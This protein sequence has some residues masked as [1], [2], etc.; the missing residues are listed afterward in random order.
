MIATKEY[1]I[2]TDI[3]STTT[4]AILLE[5][6]PLRIVAQKS[7]ATTV[8]APYNDV[9]FGVKYAIRALE[10]QSGIQLLADK[11]D[12]PALGFVPGIQYLSSSSAGGGLQILVIGLT[13]FDSANSAKRAAYGAGGIIL[14]TFAIN[15]K[16]QASQQMLAMRKLHPDMILLSGGTDGGA[17]SGVLR[18]AE[19]MRVAK[20][21]PKYDTSQKIPTIY[22]GNKE[23]APMIE[24]MI[25]REFDL[26]VLPNL[27][28]AMDSENLA[29][30]QAKIQELFM[31]NVME[32]A[33]GY[34]HLKEVVNHNILP[35][36]LGVI[37]SLGIFAA[38]ERLNI[39]AFDIGGATTDAFSQIN[40][41]FHR[42][43][44]ANFG[45]SYSALN[46]LKEAG[47]ANLMRWLSDNTD[48]TK[49]RNYIGNKCLYPTSLPQN[50]EELDFERALAREALR[51]A[52]LQH[53][54][55]H[56]EA[57]K[58][59]YLDK[60]MSNEKDGFDRKFNYLHY[61]EEHQ[62]QESEIDMI[63]AAGGIF[64]HNPDGLDKAL[65]II[66]ALQPK[67]ITRIAVD[68]DFTS[69]HWGVLSESDASAAEHLLQSQCIE[70]IA[71]HVAPIFPKGHKKGKLV[72]TINKEGKIQELTLSAGEFEII[73]AGSKSVSFEIKGK[74]YLDIKG[75]DNSLATDLP[76]IVDMR[77][78]EIAPIKR[79]SP[80]PEATHK[81]PLP[82]AELTISAQMPRRRNILLPYKG[83]T[84]YAA[85]AKVNASDIVAANRF[86]PPRLF[87]VDGMRRFGKLDSELL[88]QAFKVKVGD[89]AD[90]DV[91]LA[92]LPDN[93]NWPGYLR[94]SLKVLNPVRGRVE[95]IDYH[96]GLVVLSEIQDY[97]VKP[98][99][100]KVAELLGVPPK[101]IGRYM[102]RQPG[103]F[104]FSGETIARHKGNF[105]T[106]P[107][108]HFVRA[109]N[110]GTI[111]NL[112]TKAGTV[113]IR[114]ISQPM[115]FAAHVHGTV[116]EVVEDQSISLEY[117]ARR[118][119]GILGLGA[120]SSGPL[121]LI[122]EDTILP[123]PSLQG[124]IAACTFAPQPQ[125]LKALKDSG[126]AGLICHAM[127]E[128]VL[129][130]FTGVE[131]GVINTGNE[132]LPYGILLLA[133]FS[134]Q[135]MP[136][137]LHSSLSTLQQSHCFLMPHTRIRAGVVRP[138]ADFL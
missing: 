6:E 76:I 54:Q 31:E 47:T 28:P 40:N 58:V 85:G 13:V 30:T 102:E 125:H 26:Y 129:R 124:A 86:N 21:Q 46:V 104:V 82:K 107:A 68:K 118:L 56:F 100:I 74:G 116:T 8:E 130:D 52:Y 67:G 66:D 131:L 1:T 128:D 53:C 49:L 70:T 38:K 113:E 65:I 57:S 55:M 84:R 92:E 122:R 12:S 71:W 72:C 138:F 62:F 120:D 35:T 33:P 18:M 24:N 5:N 136:Q 27:R 90:Y 60:V 78:G 51:M 23:A 14:D 121:R 80:A 117:S 94:N 22:A 37:R 95:F 96:T 17:I 123:D 111:T 2:I 91:V 43:V 99:T 101:R 114:Y 127:D 108:Y 119:D 39:L 126:I 98:I 59:G 112:D 15:D 16:R 79:A 87:I 81:A 89:E 36:P 61:E 4:K 73:P 10:N 93:P 64:A 137:S 34:L 77:K 83:E 103:D 29:P 3:G 69:P 11:G 9:R 134:R 20:P 97:S 135:P 50:K 106:N 48:S 109:P 63:I 88:R 105:K 7:S 110:T 132:V 41:H 115:E 32:H 133:G 44:S 45:M 42:T 25:E 19:I 75:K